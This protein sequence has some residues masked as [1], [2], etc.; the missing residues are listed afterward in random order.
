MIVLQTAREYD[1]KSIFQHNVEQIRCILSAQ[2]FFIYC[3]ALT[4]FVPN[5]SVASYFW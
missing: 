2:F 1:S 3:V 5:I 4:K